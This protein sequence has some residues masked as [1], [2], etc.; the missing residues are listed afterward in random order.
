MKMSIV[1]LVACLTL[2]LAGGC[3]MMSQGCNG[4]GKDLVALSGQEQA[5]E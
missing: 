3:K 4:L 1:I 2:L 5:T